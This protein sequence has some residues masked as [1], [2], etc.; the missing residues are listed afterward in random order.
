MILESPAPIAPAPH[1]L[2]N[3]DLS[4]CYAAKIAPGMSLAVGQEYENKIH[5]H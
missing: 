2:S 1:E 3:P 4:L 5:V